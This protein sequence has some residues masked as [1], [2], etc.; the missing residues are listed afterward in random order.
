[1][2]ALAALGLAALTRFSCALPEPQQG[3]EH[4]TVSGRAHAGLV[5]AIL[6]GATIVSLSF[7]DGMDSQARAGPV[8]ARHGMH[9]TFFINSGR[10]GRRGYLTLAQLQELTAAGNEI[11]S[12]T[13]DHIDLANV[14]LPEARHQ[15]CDDRVNLMRLGFPVTSFAYPFG[16]DSSDIRQLVKGCNFNGAMATGG[17]R[18]PYG[19][20]SCPLAETLPPSDVFVIH[21]PPSV[22]TTWTLADMQSLVTQA[23]NA[24]GGWVIISLHRI[25]EGCD[26]YTYTVSEQQLEDFL[27][28]L[29]PRASQ[30]TY[31]MTINDVIGGALKPPVAGD[32]GLV[33]AGF[34]FPDAGVPDAGVPD[35]GVPDAGVPDAGVP[36]AGVAIALP[37]AS[38][39]AD[40]LGISLP[41]CWKRQSPG[42]TDGGWLRT[43]EAHSGSWAQ[44]ARIN[45]YSSGDRRLVVTQDTGTCAPRATPG[46]R[47]RVSGWY[48]TDAPAGFVATYRGSSGWVTWTQGPALPL[49]PLTYL[50]GEWETPPLPAGATHLSVG[51]ALRGVGALVMDD[52]AL[53]E[54]R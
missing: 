18:N 8:L 29:E 14:P 10:I 2:S 38:L 44:R 19:C 45:S 9:A 6:P 27:A 7:S 13:V 49:S 32:G 17:I 31:V 21:T 48:R 39:E 50:R 34:P 54:L 37:N 30:N 20:P 3:P 12:H 52:F 36:D 16:A 28:W 24:G 22:E 35:A 1:V 42:S 47:Y 15:I 33:D 53:E 41:D 11:G 4:V 43:P 23:E 25:C 46:H 40:T 26:I 51:L 5:P